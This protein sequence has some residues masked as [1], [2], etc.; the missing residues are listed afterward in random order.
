MLKRLR[1]DE[2]GMTLIEITIVIVILGLL[3]SFI[4]PRVLSA[5]DKAKVAK[6][7]QELAALENALQMYSIA[8]G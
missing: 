1:V 5:P 7:K 3:A 6:A 2:S 8:V 4:A